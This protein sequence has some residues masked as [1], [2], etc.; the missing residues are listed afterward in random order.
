MQN[1]VEPVLI[2]VHVRLCSLYGNCKSTDGYARFDPCHVGT[3][4]LSYVSVLC[5]Y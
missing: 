3:C 5:K 1:K 2:G 4:V